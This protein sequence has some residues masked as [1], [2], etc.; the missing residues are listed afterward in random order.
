MS[1]TLATSYGVNIDT[2]CQFGNPAPDHYGRFRR[3]DRGQCGRYVVIDE[4]TFDSNVTGDGADGAGIGGSGGPGGGA[5]L[6]VDL[7]LVSGCSFT[8]NVVGS[9]ASGSAA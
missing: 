4:V 6:W 8:S 3:R 2:I 9:G 1:S 5:Q 7:A